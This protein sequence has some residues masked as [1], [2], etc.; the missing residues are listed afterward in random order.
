VFLDNPKDWNSTYY[1]A[2]F[3][4][5]KNY[6]ACLTYDMPKMCNNYHADFNL[7]TG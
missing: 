3:D 5:C 6:G 2:D 7:Y 1:V 4:E